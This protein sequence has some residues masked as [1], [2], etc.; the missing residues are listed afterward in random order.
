MNEQFPGLVIVRSRSGLARRSFL[1]LAAAAGAAGPLL[2]LGREPIAWGQT[3]KKGGTL[4]VGINTDIVSL[5]PNDIVFANVP[6]FFQLYDYLVTFSTNL[7]PQPDL[8]ESWELAK[9]GTSAV[10]RLRERV[11]THSGGVFEAEALLA[12]FQRIKDKQ[13]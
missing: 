6:M 13:T 3:P 8:A 1:R 11:R 5:D 7:E 2:E 10:F 4:T 9:D 12:N